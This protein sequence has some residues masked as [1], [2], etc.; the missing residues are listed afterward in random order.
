MEQHYFKKQALFRD[1]TPSWA[2]TR[3]RPPLFGAKFLCRQSQNSAHSGKSDM[4]GSALVIGDDSDGSVQ[5]FD[6]R[7]DNG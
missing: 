3:M 4:K 7:P 2:E 5:F 1:L 6:N